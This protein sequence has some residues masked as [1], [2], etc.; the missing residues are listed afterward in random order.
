ML[1]MGNI[2]NPPQSFAY[3]YNFEYDIGYVGDLKAET[4]FSHINSHF[5]SVFAYPLGGDCGS[6]LSVGQ[7][8]DLTAVKDHG[9][10]NVRVEEVGSRHYVFIT[11]EG[12]FEGANKRI[13]FTLENRGDHLYLVVTASGKDNL[14]QKIPGEKRLNRVAADTL[15]TQFATNIAYAAGNL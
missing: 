11:R 5:N 12:H 2:V 3:G 13:N 4:V 15:W 6:Q 8:C 7:E 14:M 1:G 9:K 10:G